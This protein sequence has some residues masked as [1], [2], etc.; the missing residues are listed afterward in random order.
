MSLGL[1]IYQRGCITAHTQTEVMAAHLL[2]NISLWDVRQMLI[3]AV[4]STAG[5]YFLKLW[6]LSP[7]TTVLLT[8]CMKPCG[9]S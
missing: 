1:C 6:G 9:G 8:I 5:K 3:Y 4:N 2:P 7:S